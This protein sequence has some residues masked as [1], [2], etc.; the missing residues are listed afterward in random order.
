MHYASC[1]RFALSFVDDRDVAQDV[2]QDV[3][4]W[5]WLHRAE[6]TPSHDVV[7]YLLTAVRNRAL[8]I[9]RTQQRRSAT[10]AR[11]VALGDSPAMASAETS[12]DIIIEQAEQSSAIWHA[13]NALPEQRRTVLLLRWRH[14]LGWDEIARVM[15]ASVGAVQVN[16]TRALKALRERFPSVLR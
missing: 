14:G 9:V 6:W 13:V 7:S 15:G 1:F 3:F 16:H 5:L 11:H 12:A 8:D 4:G 2:T 10:V